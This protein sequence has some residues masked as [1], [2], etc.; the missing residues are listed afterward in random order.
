MEPEAVRALHV[1]LDSRALP[2]RQIARRKD[3]SHAELTRQFFS[4]HTI[5]GPC[6]AGIGFCNEQEIAV[7]EAWVAPQSIHL[8]VEAAAAFNVPR[9]PP[10]ARSSGGIGRA[11]VRLVNAAEES[12]EARGKRAVERVREH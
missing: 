12:L 8:Q 4:H 3:L 5:S 10:V 7:A 2:Q 1:A 11:E 6:H 9:H